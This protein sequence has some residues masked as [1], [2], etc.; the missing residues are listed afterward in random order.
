MK[1]KKINSYILIN[2]IFVILAI[3]S[4]VITFISIK[5]MGQNDDRIRSIG[6]GSIANYLRFLP[7]QYKNQD[8]LELAFHNFGLAF[9]AY[10]LSALSFGILGIL[11]LCSAFSVA[12]VIF[13]SS[14]DWLTVVFTCL[15][16]LG[17]S[18]S[19]FGGT[20]IFNKRRRKNISL[21]KVF[22]FSSVLICILCVIYLLAA[23]IE[24]GLIRNMLR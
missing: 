24:T 18:L 10:I 16:V 1:I 12:A 6:I 21:K 2:C 15:E 3:L 17:I 5:Q 20:Y 22:A 7:S 14:P 9:I 23:Y 19:V 11:S 13:S 8:I 4:F